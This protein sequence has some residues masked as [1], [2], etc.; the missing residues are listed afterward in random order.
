MHP[1][2]RFV[3]HEPIE[4][5][6][7]R[8]NPG[9]CGNAKAPPW[10]ELV[11]HPSDERSTNGR[12]AHEDRHVQGHHA[13]PRSGTSPVVCTNEFAVVMNMREAKPMR[14]RDTVNIS[15][16]GIIAETPPRE[17]PKSA[18]EV[19]SVRIL[20]RSCLGREQCARNRT[21]G[22]HG[23]EHPELCCSLV[24]RDR[25]HGRGVDRKVQA[26][27]ADDSDH[28]EDDDNGGL[29]AHI[30]EPGN[31][32]AARSRGAGLG[33]QF[34]HSDRD[35]GDDGADERPGVDD[36]HPSGSN[37][38]DE[39]ACDSGAEQPSRVKGHRVK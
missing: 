37:D 19:K 6:G 30:A 10:T 36:E 14:V 35:E 39:N 8:E 33:A 4:A 12:S 27:G 31:Y 28:D 23:T 24:E 2:L 32:L 7:C 34:A 20:G 1:S 25:R 21:D 17:T 15:N 22:H 26:E 29:L 9:D 16:V 13:T 18:A 5:R 3:T 38:G 11:D